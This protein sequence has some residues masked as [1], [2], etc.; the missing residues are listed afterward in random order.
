MSVDIISAPVRDRPKG[1]QN[2]QA[3]R[4]QPVEGTCPWD[5]L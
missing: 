4:V 3:N 2:T 1:G 5:M